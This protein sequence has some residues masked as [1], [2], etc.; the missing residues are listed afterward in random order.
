MG[1]FISRQRYYDKN[2]ILAV[3][4][5]NGGPKQASPDILP[6]TY[7]GEGKNLIDPRDAVNVAY[8]IYKQ[9]I[10]SR[11]LDE[12]VHLV[13]KDAD[14]SYM[15]DFSKKGLDTA[16]KWANDTFN[17]SPKCGSCQRV[18]NTKKYFLVNGLDGVYCSEVCCASQYRQTYKKEIKA[19]DIKKP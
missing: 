12:N 6:E 7:E 18:M 17:R 4:I 15:L 11:C 1:Y 8:K 3:E 5:A 2:R 19:S 13:I 14:R 9:W 16:N 10:S